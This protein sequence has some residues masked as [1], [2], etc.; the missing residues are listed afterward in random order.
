MN[1]MLVPCP[2]QGHPNQCDFANMSWLR[3]LPSRTYLA[4]WQRWPETD[5]PI[6]HDAYLVSFHLEAVDT[7]WLDRQCQRLAAPI[8]VLF[9]GSYYD[10][11]HALNL[12][13]IP[14][15]YWHHQCHKMVHWFG[16]VT[17][18]KK[19]THKASAFCSR[20]T[21]S[22][23]LIF[24]ALAEYFESDQCFLVLSDW[25]EEKNTHHRALTGHKPLDDIS[26]I[27]WS[28]YW[29]KIYSIDDYDQSLNHQSHTANFHTDPYQKTALHFTNESYHYSLMG[30]HCRPGP[31]IT[32]KTLKS[33]AAGQ[34]FVPVGQYDT[35]GTL[36]RLGFQFDYDFD[37]SWDSDAG[38]LSRLASIMDLIKNL[39]NWSVADIEAAVTA[40]S[41]HNLEHLN[42]GDFSKTCEQLNENSINQVLDMLQS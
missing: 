42:S 26:A 39:S 18:P 15:F 5:L 11:P 2:W 33:L 27:F 14:F 19:K 41:R 35:Y 22:K 28:K 23:L 34:A 13:P 29:G 24:T 3:D 36:T 16:K 9:D 8:L 4:L 12:H 31:F 30:R 10:W 40:S 7:D 37:T 20:I 17:E 25:L 32:E 21:Q 38:N 1:Q 6:G